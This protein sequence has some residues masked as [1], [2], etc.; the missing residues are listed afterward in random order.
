MTLTELVAWAW[1]ETVPVHENRTN[2]LIHLAAVPAFGIGHV[3]VV[4]G[5]PQRR[6][7]ALERQQVHAFASPKDF[8][9]RL[10]AEQFCNF[11]RFLFSGG[12]Y[13]SFKRNRGAP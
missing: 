8:V 10:Y 2:L 4:V 12:W 5:V 11:W 6:G 13:A 9:R 7:H 3:M 1:E